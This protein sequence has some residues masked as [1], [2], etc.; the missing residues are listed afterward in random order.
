[1]A[2]LEEQ[3]QQ[4]NNRLET[5]WEVFKLYPNNIGLA[6]NLDKD[7]KKIKR[8]TTKEDI[9]NILIKQWNKEHPHY[10]INS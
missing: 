9:R 4:I 8:G 1:M 10:K 2:T 5:I 6:S 3:I 7:T